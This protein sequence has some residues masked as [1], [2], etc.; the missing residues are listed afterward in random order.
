MELFVFH[1]YYIAILSMCSE[2]N[3][4]YIIAIIALFSLLLWRG[5]S[6]DVQCSEFHE[7]YKQGLEEDDVRERFVFI[8]LFFVYGYIFICLRTDCASNHT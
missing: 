2:T 4:I 5:M 3:N 8:Y 6:K 1:V 7:E